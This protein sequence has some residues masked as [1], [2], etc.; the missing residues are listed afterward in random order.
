MS[1]VVDNNQLIGKTLE[2]GKAYA[3]SIG[4]TLRVTKKDGE[5]M[6][7]TMDFRPNRINVAIV[8]NIITEVLNM[9]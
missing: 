6:M 3:E 8:N 9:G 2:E 5:G 1:Y 4:C 7:V